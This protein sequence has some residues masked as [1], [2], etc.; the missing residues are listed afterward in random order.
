MTV[1]NSKEFLPDNMEAF[2]QLAEDHPDISYY[3][4]GA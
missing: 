1:Q 4:L 2:N 3:S